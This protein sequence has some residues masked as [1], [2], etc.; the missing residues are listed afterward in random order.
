MGN[1]CH[2]QRVEVDD[3]IIYNML[4]NLNLN[5]IEV[6]S[7]YNHFLKC[8]NREECYLD[9]FMYKNYI[10]DIVG[11][12]IYKIDQ[13]SYF[14]NLGKL[15][16]KNLNVK[17]IGII[18]ILLSKGSS[19]E[20]IDC[21]FKH[22]YIFYCLSDERTVREFLRDV[23][24]VHTDTLLIYRGSTNRKIFHTIWKKDRKKLLINEIYQNF[25]FVKKKYS[26]WR[27][28]LSQTD[29]FKPHKEDVIDVERY[30]NTHCE[31]FNKLRFKFI[32]DKF[33]L[34]KEE[35]IIREFLELSFTQLS[36]EYVRTWLYEES[37]KERSDSVCLN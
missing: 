26:E 12:S 3:E 22:Y 32:D 24:N 31:F 30:N 16:R 21:L 14:E 7:S 8:Y 20:K 11:N 28:K 1:T 4:N 10:N 23:I 33:S 15:D 29:N 9:Y 5:D 17:L 13:I 27:T 18:I 36:G 2:C 6:K 25:I 34:N 35:L 19:Y 37:M